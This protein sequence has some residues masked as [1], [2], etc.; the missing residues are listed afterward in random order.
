MP[1][2]SEYPLAW[3]Y[4][5]AAVV[6]GHGLFVAVGVGVQTAGF[7]P[8]MSYSSVLTS[9]DG[10]NWTQ[11]IPGD[12]GVGPS[13]V[14]VAY[15]NS[16]FAA[17]GSLGLVVTSRDGVN[18]APQS[19]YD[20]GDNRLNAVSFGNN[21]FVSVGEKATILQSRFVLNDCAATLVA[22]FLNVPI[23]KVGEDYYQA[24][25]LSAG[26]PFADGSQFQ[27]GHAEKVVDAASFN[28]CEPPSLSC[29]GPDCTLHVPGIGVHVTDVPERQYIFYRADFQLMQTLPGTVFLKLISFEPL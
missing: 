15:G 24:Q 5:L 29:T 1:P 9:P 16:Q 21:T 13:L 7:G 22:F 26:G 19:V 4:G 14:D 28:D 18:W 12:G 11:I 20:V 2:E 23:I 25:F 3:S 6:F 8:P 10:L 17:V 27:L